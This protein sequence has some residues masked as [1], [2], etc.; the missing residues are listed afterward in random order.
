MHVLM[1]VILII[2]VVLMALIGVA[3]G[4][5][6]VRPGAL[7]PAPMP[8]R[9]PQTTTMPKD[10]PAP[11]AR[12][13]QIAVGDQVPIIES[14]IISGRG[15]IRLNGVRFPA[16]YRFT[17]QAG[18]SYRHYIET[19]LYGIPLFKVNEWYLEGHARMELPVGVIEN[20]A[21]TDM[22]A[23]LGLWGE[24]LFLP[25]VFLTDPR[26][27]WEAID[28]SH[29]RLIVPFGEGTD[30]FTA[31]FD[32]E[33]GLIESMEAMRWKA[34]GDASKTLWRL[35]ARAWGRFESLLMPTAWA[36][37]WA[38]EEQP[39][40]VADVEEAAYNMDVTQYIRATGP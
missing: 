15:H 33:T 21:K 31:A 28:E 34:P 10:L 16:R 23:N 22:A 1:K 14:A 18:Q 17:H 4:G 11:V 27:R 5:L 35:E 29:A 12:F 25:A 19:T 9:T 3:Y 38:D 39:W 13:F 8:A 26:V 2:L 6:F 36:L 40:F 7:Q 20:D 24:T 32:A 30:S 37:K